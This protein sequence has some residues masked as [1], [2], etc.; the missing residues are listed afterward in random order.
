MTSLFIVESR[1][2]RGDNTLGTGWE[3]ADE[4]AKSLKIKRRA[5]VCTNGRYPAQ[6]AAAS[7]SLQAWQVNSCDNRLDLMG[8]GGKNGKW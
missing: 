4:N 7:V 2:L 1:L 3:C 5:E 6:V 8:N